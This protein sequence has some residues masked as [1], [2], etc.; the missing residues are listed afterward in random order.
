M[1]QKTENKFSHVKPGDTKFL[2][3]GLRDFFL[4]RDLGITDATTAILGW[5]RN[6]LTAA[7]MGTPPSTS[8]PGANT[9]P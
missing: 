3:G 6:C 8:I 9:L 5:A 7:G 1:L 4:Y 2:S